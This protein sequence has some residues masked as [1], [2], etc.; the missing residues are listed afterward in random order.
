MTFLKQVGTLMG[1]N[2]RILLMRHLALCIWMAFILP[3]FLAALFSFT[4]NLLVP[5]A[6]FGIGDVA[7][8]MP[9]N[10]AIEKA[11]DNG[12][13]K[14][15]LVNNANNDTDI[16]SVFDTVKTQFEDAA[17]SAGADFEV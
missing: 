9:L 8:L 12:R 17:Q 10:Q 16:N 14:L 1:K 3:I 13:E 15:V 2:F 5:P 4:K 7:P 11:T 6:K